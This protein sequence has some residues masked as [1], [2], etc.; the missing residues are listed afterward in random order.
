MAKLSFSKKIQYFAER[1]EW[2]KEEKHIEGIYSELEKYGIN[3][4][5]VT[6]EETGKISYRITNLVDSTSEIEIYEV[7]NI[8]PNFSNRDIRIQEIEED[9]LYFFGN[10]GI[11]YKSMQSERIEEVFVAEDFTI[12]AIKIFLDKKIAII[13]GEDKDF[14]VKF[15][16]GKVIQKVENTQIWYISNERVYKTRYFHNNLIF[17]L[18]NEK[19]LVIFGDEGRFGFYNINEEIVK[20]E[21]W[22]ESLNELEKFLKEDLV[23]AYDSENGYYMLISYEKHSN[24]I[25]R[26][27]DFDV[28]EQIDEKYYFAYDND[29]KFA[30]IIMKQEDKSCKKVEFFSIGTTPKGKYEYVAGIFG[31]KIFKMKKNESVIVLTIM[32]KEVRYKCY[33]NAVDVE[34]LLEDELVSDR[35]LYLSPII[36]HFEE[37]LDN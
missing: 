15:E 37:S 32:E 36:P 12:N 20:E 27:Y 33:K 28:L 22:L 3:L 18:H 9:G 13:L 30:T 4:Y 21:L 35:I 16:A 26:W 8:N 1:R 7:S 10:K 34:I 17:P 2:L 25:K 19:L 31:M 5:S 6:N 14:V 29:S 23:K 11:F 24:T